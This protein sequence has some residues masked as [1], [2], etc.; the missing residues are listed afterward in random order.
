MR[1]TFRN[2]W[3]R[4]HTVQYPEE[5]RQVASRYQGVPRLLRDEDGRNKCVACHL[6]STA[7]PAACIRIEAAEAPWG[8]G[9]RHPARFE[10]DA[11]RCIFCGY[12]VAACPEA[13]IAM[14]GRR[15]L[16]AAAREELVFD[17]ER[18]L[19]T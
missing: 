19:A 4:K 12:C 16:V 5:Q 7:C 9:E 3:S 14:S 8:D 2:F 1:V 11:L 13:A 10:I 18:L 15:V 17:E 6:C